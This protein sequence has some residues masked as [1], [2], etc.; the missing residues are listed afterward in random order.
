MPYQICGLLISSVSCLLF[1]SSFLLCRT[2]YFVVV[3]LVY[4]CS[5]CCAFGVNPKNCCQDQ[6]QGTCSL[7]VLPGMF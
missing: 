2:Y 5:Y 1:L 3:P 7:F 6:Y 4:F